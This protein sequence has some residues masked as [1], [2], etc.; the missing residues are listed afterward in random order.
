LKSQVVHGTSAVAPV[1][2]GAVST[3]TEACRLPCDTLAL[4]QLMSWTFKLRFVLSR[5]FG[6]HKEKGASVD[7]AELLNSKL[8]KL[9]PQ[10][11]TT[12]ANHGFKPCSCNGD[13]STRTCLSRLE[14][15]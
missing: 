3:P 12:A 13:I 7:S 8:R 6:L 10:A 4:S 14:E 5:R 11:S 15:Y 2:T 9:S 1:T